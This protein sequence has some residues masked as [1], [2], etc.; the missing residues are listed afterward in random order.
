[1]AQGVAEEYN[2]SPKDTI[3]HESL[4]KT[5]IKLLVDVVEALIEP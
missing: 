1:M 4:K 3:P 5:Q 2:F